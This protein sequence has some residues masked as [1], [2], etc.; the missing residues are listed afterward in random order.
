MENMRSMKVKVVLITGAAQG[1]GLASAK[2]F[3][4]ADAQVILADARQW[5]RKCWKGNPM[6]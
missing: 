2:A 6:R 4:E 3:A 1:I 5:L